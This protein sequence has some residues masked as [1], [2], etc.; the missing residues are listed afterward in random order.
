[1]STEEEE[2][3]RRL[4]IEKSRK[5]GRNAWKGKSKKKRSEIM[6]ERQK[7]RWAKIKAQGQEVNGIQDSR[8]R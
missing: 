2:I 6:S 3:Y 4:M 1:M 5:G 7:K 8:S